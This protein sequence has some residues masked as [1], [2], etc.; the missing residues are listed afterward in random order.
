MDEYLIC[1][2]IV[3]KPSKVSRKHSARFIRIFKKASSLGI[4][5]MTALVTYSEE[6]TQAPEVR[7]ELVLKPM[8]LAKSNRVVA[9]N[10]TE[11]Q[12]TT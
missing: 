1:T 4:T 8:R 6:S 9:L 11:Y 10:I 5:Q 2:F 7:T 3:R 12:P